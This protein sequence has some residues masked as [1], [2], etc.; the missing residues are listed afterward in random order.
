MI[1]IRPVKALKDNYI[2]LIGNTTHNRV[3]IVDPG[4]AVP[5]LD[6]L[7]DQGLQPLAILVTHHHQDHGGGIIE[8]LE[9][10][11]VTVYGPAG[12]D[13]PAITN[14]L[15]EGDVVSLEGI[16]LEL[17]V[18]EV[19][20]HT[21]GAL[22]YHGS[23]AA[24]TGDTLFTAGCGRLFEGT[25]EQLYDSL[26]KLYRLPDS[27]MI[28]CGHEYTLSNLAFAKVVEPDNQA[29]V[30]RLYACERLRQE[31]RPTVP[32]TLAEERLTNPF[33]RTDQPSVR[34]AASRHA[35]YSPE[36]AV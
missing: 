27:T 22:A 29:I 36:N 9:S 28:Y 18:L 35:G 5:I 31:N 24:F 23:D 32:A 21:M 4:D 25:P 14:P 15:H 20:G 8:L 19:P 34:A 6:Q 13:I 10:Y 11:Q 3:A 1:E 7:R 26:E 33:L 16:G 2:W 30:H 17:S 12:E